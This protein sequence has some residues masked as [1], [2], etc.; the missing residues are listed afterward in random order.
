MVTTSVK[1]VTTD[2]VKT[3]EVE[4]KVEPEDVTALLKSHKAASYGSAK[5]MVS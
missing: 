5:N 2:V 4:L 3:T 1:E